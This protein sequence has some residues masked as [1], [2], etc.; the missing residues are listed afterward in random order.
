M[1]RVYVGRID[2]DGTQWVR[3][4]DFADLVT[5]RDVLALRMA[6]ARDLLTEARGV[7]QADCQDGLVEA[8][9]RFMA[10]Q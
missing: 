3:H 4:K 9:D 8:I 6:E 2:D 10:R 1:P 5:E 7:A